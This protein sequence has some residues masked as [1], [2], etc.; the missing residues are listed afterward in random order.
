MV[1]LADTWHEHILDHGRG[2]REVA[3]HLA[4]CLGRL[5]RPAIT[6]RTSVPTVSHGVRYDSEGRV[7]GVTIINTRWLLGREGHMTI[8]LPQKVQV[9]P[10]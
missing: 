10:R 9:A 3:P 6:N 8:T 7:I 5:R 2:H 1:I 4:R